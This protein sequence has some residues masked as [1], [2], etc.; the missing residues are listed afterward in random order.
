MDWEPHLTV[1]EC[2]STF[3]SSKHTKKT[4]RKHLVSERHKILMMGGTKQIHDE[5]A[6]Y[7]SNITE[8]RNKMEKVEEGTERWNF[9]KEWMERD[10]EKLQELEDKWLNA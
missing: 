6:G 3:K 8:K 1:C 5:I 4:L 9:L 7:R 2:G 10:Q